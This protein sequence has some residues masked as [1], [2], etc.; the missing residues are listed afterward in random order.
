MC[1]PSVPG[2]Q[3]VHGRAVEKSP[4]CVS[5]CLRRCLRYLL[6][7]WSRKKTELPQ[8]LFLLCLC[9]CRV[10]TAIKHES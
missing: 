9:L 3:I 7:L 6:V 1:D 8:P 4:R 5:W 2:A 10:T